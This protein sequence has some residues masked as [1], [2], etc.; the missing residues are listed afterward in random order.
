MI[1]HASKTFAEHLKCTVSGPN[2]RLPHHASLDSWSIDLFKLAKGGAFALVMNDAS[3]STIIIPLKGVRNFEVFLP[4]VLARVAAFL[5]KHGAA[6]DTCNQSVI[7]L[8]RSNRSLIGTMN[9]AKFLIQDSVEHK[10]T[11]AGDID[12]D[13]L[14]S[15]LNETP[16]SRI[17]YATPDK[18]L[19]ELLAEQ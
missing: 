19:R 16:Y 1:I 7:I 12:W 13:A 6:F 4:L 15:R 10:L 8:P 5:A 3:L 11:L 9:E 17:G 18:R 14:E 2:R